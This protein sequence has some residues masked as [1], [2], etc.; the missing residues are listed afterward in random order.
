MNIREMA[1]AVTTPKILVTIT[2]GKGTEKLALPQLTVGDWK[3]I[4]RTVGTDMWEMLLSL[5][6][7]LDEEALRGKSKKERA[8]IQKKAGMEM[9]EKLGHDLQLSMFTQSLK[10]LDPEIT[11]EEVDRLISYGIQDRGEYIRAMLFFVYGIQPEA[12]EEAPLADQQKEK[13]V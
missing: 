1:N 3:Q 6:S 8:E 13:K 10:H 7:G 12:L 4:K 2:T 11:E 5:S 9:F